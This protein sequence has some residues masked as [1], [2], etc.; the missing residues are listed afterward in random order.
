MR[1]KKP[2]PVKIT[3]KDIAN[4]LT[5]N[6]AP[7]SRRRWIVVPNV[8]WGWGLRYEADL[9]AV[10]K[11]H[12]ADEIEI[13]VNKYDLLGDQEKRKFQQTPDKRIKRFWYAVPEELAELCLVT[14][15]ETAGVLV[16]SPGRGLPSRLK[17]RIARLPKK[18]QNCR[19]VTEAELLKLMHLGLMRYWSI[20]L[21]EE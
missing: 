6:G 14:V 10:S 5:Q 7:F 16:I 11:S 2:K 15:P 1:A 17:V 21:K 12:W 20:R 9:I 19:A 18:A 13:K 8:Y 4:A 3:A